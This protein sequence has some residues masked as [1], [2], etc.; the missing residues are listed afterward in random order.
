MQRYLEFK[1]LGHSLSEIYKPGHKV[2]LLA[3]DQRIFAWSN[4]GCAVTTAHSKQAFHV[5]SGG[6]CEIGIAFVTPRPQGDNL[7][8][9]VLTLRYRCRGNADEAVICFKSVE[10]PAAPGPLISNELFTRF[11]DTG[12]REEEIQVLLPA[13]PGLADIREVVITYRHGQKKR[14]LDLSITRL[15]FAPYEEAVEVQARREAT[16]ASAGGSVA[17][18]VPGNVPSFAPAAGHVKK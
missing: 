13:T 11:H 7:S 12:D 6:A 10:G 9:A 15:T 3:D 14:P 16:P 1:G 2:D 18:A 17:L 8:N 5:T 4:G